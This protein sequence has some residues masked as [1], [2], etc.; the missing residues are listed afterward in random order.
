VL[1]LAGSRELLIVGATD[2]SANSNWFKT[3]NI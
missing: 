1:I 2:I 3:P